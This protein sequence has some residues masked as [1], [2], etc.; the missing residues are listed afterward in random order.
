VPDSDAVGR[1]LEV[2][3]LSSLSSNAIL[4]IA[5]VVYVSVVEVDY[6]SVEMLLRHSCWSISSLCIIRI[7]PDATGDRN[8]MMIEF[9]PTPLNSDDIRN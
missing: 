8:R 1:F 7:I 9:F 4:D 3:A 2:V 6:V 5:M